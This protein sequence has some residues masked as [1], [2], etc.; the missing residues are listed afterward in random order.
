MLVTMQRDLDGC[1]ALVLIDGEPGDKYPELKLTI[2]R[3]AVPR[4]GKVDWDNPAQ[5]TA[6]TA[7]WR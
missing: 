5:L 2:G 4:L 3:D 6:M 1:S 7:K